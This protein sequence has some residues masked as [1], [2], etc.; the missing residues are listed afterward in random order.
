[1]NTQNVK[2][3]RINKGFYKFQDCRSN[4]S[5]LK[6]AVE[7]INSKRPREERI[8]LDDLS[9]F[10]ENGLTFY[11]FVHKH[12]HKE[13]DWGSYFPALL[14]E[15]WDFSLQNI[16]IILFID[17]DIDIFIVIGGNAFQQIVS[18][19]DH[20]FGL[21]ILSKIIEPE[22]DQ[23]LSINAR[24]LTGT[25]SGISEQYRDEIRVADFA[26]FGKLP[27][28]VHLTLSE[29]VSSEYFSHLQNNA[30]E[31]IKIHVG[32]SFKVKKSLTFAELKQLLQ[33]LGHI[34]GLEEQDYLSSYIQES[35][36]K[37]I[38]EDFQPLLIN[39]IFDDFTNKKNLGAN[40]RQNFKFDFCNPNNIVDFYGADT[41]V[42]TEK[43]GK[44]YKPFDE[45][46]NK[47]EIYDKV[48]AQAIRVF[49]GD[50][51]LF[52]FR[53]Y[54]QGI[55]VLAYQ[56]D[57]RLCSSSFLYHF[58]TEFS[59][60]PQT[61]FL[62]D[63]KW[64]RIKYSFLEDLRSETVSLLKRYKLPKEVFN[65]PYL[66][67][68]TEYKYNI[69]YHEFKNYYVFDTITQQGIELCDVLTHS[70]EAV[71]LIHV[72][73]GFDNSMRELT[74]QI[75]L[76]ARRLNTDLKS[77]EKE[78]LK[79]T[80]GSYCTKYPEIEKPDFSDFLELFERKIVFV[81]AFVSQRS[82][83][84]AV[85]ENIEKY[86]SNIAKYSMIECAIDMQEYR[87]ELNI[88]QIPKS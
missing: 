18:F 65:I 19:I 28:E 67:G 52:D 77:S 7:I 82:D 63:N 34:M 72:K 73:K 58:T 62:V 8:N 53:A 30:D 49:P 20:T 35:N 39:A 69:Q 3:Y 5:I 43:N 6:K 1:M 75:T 10:E 76:S 57:K 74:N 84:L 15:N 26:K 40:Y 55:R 29:K 27:T 61:I 70:E 51:Q 12:R 50:T 56:D 81:L 83:D 9:S 42:M 24:G 36:Q 46:H 32:K 88:H 59:F 14:T 13:S 37:V 31:R 80:W 16:S 64:Y 44:S 45:T 41:Y 23:I 87:Y 54:I 66:R 4:K 68:Q 33:E 79:K 22:E 38:S 60:G 11:L 21:K 47:D 25:R 85:V 71:Y 86:R 17:N 2:I 48:L 78:Y